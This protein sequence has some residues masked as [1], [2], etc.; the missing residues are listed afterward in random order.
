MKG[1]PTQEVEVDDYNSI[2]VG[3]A[4]SE[5]TIEYGLRTLQR[6]TS[7]QYWFLSDNQLFINSGIGFSD[8]LAGTVASTPARQEF[9]S[10]YVR[11][12]IA[13]GYSIR[14]EDIDG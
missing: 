3:Q 2:N 14:R 4:M 1:L 5:S 13:I 12:T 7:D 6:F 10:E 8:G 9:S 11:E